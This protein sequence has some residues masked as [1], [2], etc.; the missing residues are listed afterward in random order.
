V[1]L[2]R[3]LYLV[4]FR[5]TPAESDALPVEVDAWLMPVWLAIAKIEAR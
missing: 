5:L 2:R 4:K 1:T 3:C